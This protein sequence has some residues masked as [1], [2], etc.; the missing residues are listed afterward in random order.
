MCWIKMI[1]LNEE[2]E[3]VTIMCL[4]AHPRSPLSK[5]YSLRLMTFLMPVDHLSDTTGKISNCQY[6]SWSRLKKWS[7]F[8]ERIMTRTERQTMIPITWGKLFLPVAAD[9][10]H[11]YS[12]FVNCSY[13]LVRIEYQCR[14]A[15][16]ESLSCSMRLDLDKDPQPYSFSGHPF[17][18]SSSMFNW[19]CLF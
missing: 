13:K 14:H 5:R 18:W 8:Y 19:Y 7:A 4:I 11:S 16:F 6:P 1:R 3:R 17:T 12:S 9:V 15:I 2:E 10:A